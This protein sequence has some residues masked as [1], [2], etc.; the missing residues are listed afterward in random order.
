MARNHPPLKLR[1]GTEAAILA[2]NVSDFEVGEPIFAS[3]TGKLFIKNTAGVLEEISGSGDGSGPGGPV[4]WGSI[5]GTLASQTDLQTALD[6]KTDLDDLPQNVDGTLNLAQES[7]L[8]GLTNRVIAAGDGLTGG[9]DLTANRTLAVSFAGTGNATTV[10]RSNHT[11]AA[12][13]LTTDAVTTGYLKWT[14]ASGNGTWSVDPISVTAPDFI[15]GGG[16]N[17]DSGE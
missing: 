6:L 13:E 17:A 16:A 4:S 8:L 10:S 2:A 5:T 12:T 7:T 3:D 1:R 9:G 14:Y 15:N 11:H